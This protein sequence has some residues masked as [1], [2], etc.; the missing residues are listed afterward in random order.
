L[1]GFFCAVAGI[2]QAAQELKG[3]PEAGMTYEL[4]AITMKV[5]YDIKGGLF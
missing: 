2:S 5:L 3:D 1:S 4:P